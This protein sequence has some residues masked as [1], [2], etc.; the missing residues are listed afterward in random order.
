MVEYVELHCHSYFSLLDGASSPEALVARA[1]VLG[2]PALALTDHN[3]LY[4][5]VRFWQAAREHGIK[6]IVGAEVSL[7]PPGSHPGERTQGGRRMEGGARGTPRGAVPEGGHLTLLAMDRRGYANLCR[8]ISAGQLAG[9]KGQPSL[10]LDAVAVRSAG[11]ICLSG[12]RRG[13]V[14]GA[15]LA[16][17]GAG[18]R[19]IAGRLRDLFGPERFWIEI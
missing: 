10:T 7:V 9:Q 2:Y 1:A 19:Q 6:A 15:L 12:C 11:L 8:L 14:P 13:P 5:A 18:A 4:G 17:D 3:G 16:G